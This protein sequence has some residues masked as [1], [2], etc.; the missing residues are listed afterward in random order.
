MRLKILVC[1]ADEKMETSQALCSK[2]AFLKGMIDAT[3][4]VGPGD[5]NRNFYLMNQET[6]EGV[7]RGGGKGFW[8]FKPYHCEQAVRK[9]KDG[10][11]IIYAD[12][13]VEFIASIEPIIELMD[14]NGEDIFLFGNGH[15]HAQ[16]TKG[17][18]LAHMLPGRNWQTLGEQVQASVMFF[19]VNDYT[20]RFCRRWLAWAQVPGFIDDSPSKIPNHPEFKDGRNDQSILTC[21]AIQDDIKRHWWPVQY[22]HHIRGQY[23]ADDN[24]GQLFYHHRY[25]ET[26]WKNCGLTIEQFMN[27]PKNT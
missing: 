1:Y 13:G 9:S 4:I 11:I 3:D 5:I 15:S 24:Y 26:D 19:R 7:Q 16:W 22:G 8:L 6:L 17:D 10:T 14:R 18:V 25:R 12:S 20:R 21:L 2:S 23:S 27:Q